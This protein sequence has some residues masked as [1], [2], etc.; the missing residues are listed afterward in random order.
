VVTI[1]CYVKQK[2]NTDLQRPPGV[3]QYA[4]YCEGYLVNP[5]TFALAGIPLQGHTQ[6]VPLTFDDGV[7]GEI[8]LVPVIQSSAVVNYDYQTRLGEKISGWFHGVN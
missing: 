4:I 1:D 8:V 6:P 5:E 3:N 7:A 2:Q